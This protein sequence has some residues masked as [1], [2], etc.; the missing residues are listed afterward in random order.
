MSLTIW[1]TSL[2]KIVIA[3]RRLVRILAGGELYEAL[4]AGLVCLGPMSIMTNVSPQGRGG[5]Q[6][7][8]A[9]VVQQ[10][11]QHIISASACVRACMHRV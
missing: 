10:T 1:I 4:M 3:S 9:K 5:P 6:C 7:K 11:M 2:G 8:A